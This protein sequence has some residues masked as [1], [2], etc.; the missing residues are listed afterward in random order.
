MYRLPVEINDT[1]SNILPEPIDNTRG[2]AFQSLLSLGLITE[3]LHTTMLDIVKL[4]LQMEAFSQFTLI[5]PKIVALMNMR[6]EIYHRLLQQPTGVELELLTGVSQQ[7]YECSR[8]ASMIYAAAVIFPIPSSTGCPQRLVS[9]LRTAMNDL[10]FEN[11]YGN[12]ARA[13]IW[14][15]FLAGVA[16]QG[17]PQRP[18]FAQRLRSLLMLERISRWSEVKSLVMSFLWIGSVCDEGAMELWDDVASGLR[19]PVGGYVT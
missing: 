7:L 17:M 12:E 5:N 3:D 15:L 4:T 2:T 16:A 6:C 8:L 1:S 9:L 19:T 18:W 13:M 10:S 14:I 11:L